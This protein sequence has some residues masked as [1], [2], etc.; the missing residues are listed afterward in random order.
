MAWLIMG[1]RRQEL[2]G[3]VNDHTLESMKLKSQ[4]DRLSS[5][6][7]AIGDGTITPTEISSLG[8]DLFGDALDFM[9]YAN[10]A[11]ENT[12]QTQTD[13]Y[14]SVYGNLTQEQYFNNSSISSQAALYYDEN[15]Q[16]DEQKIFSNFYDEALKEFAE[17][18]FTPYLNEKE[19]EI[20]AKQA[21]L[22]TL[23]ESEK[24]ELEEL[25]GSISSQIQSNALKLS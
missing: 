4:L 12:A 20:Q 21:E 24:A 25:K 8:S 11:A 13:Y 5:F 6:S 9:Q 14:T 19:K 16:L 7:G 15:G 2:I 22:E 17:K 1:L 18:Y 23:I 3:N 10:E